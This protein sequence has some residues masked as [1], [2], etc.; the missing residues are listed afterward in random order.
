M[1]RLLKRTTLAKGPLVCC[2]GSFLFVIASISAQTTARPMNITPAEVAR[3]TARMMSHYAP[4]NMLRFTISLKSPRENELRQFNEELYDKNSPNFHK[5]LTPEQWIAR[6]APPA[7]DE[8]VVLDW[9]RSNGLTVTAQHPHRLTVSLEGTSERIES[10]FAVRMNNYQIGALSFYSND[11]DPVLPAQLAAVVES[12]DGL[13]SKAELSPASTGKRILHE[14]PAYVAGPVIAL[15][16]NGSHDADRSK[17]PAALA[18]SLAS[19]LAA[20][21]AADSADPSFTGS[22]LDPTDLYSPGAYNWQALNNLKHCCNPAHGA[23]SPREA[24]VAIVTAYA[25]DPADITGFHNAYSYLADHWTSFNIDGTPKC[26]TTDTSCNFET[27]LDFDSVT[28]MANSF[29]SAA[30]TAHVYIYQ[31]VSAQVSVVIDT[32]SQ[33]LTDNKV[34]VVTHSFGCAEGDCWNSSNMKS[35]HNVFE[36]MIAQGYTIMVDAGDQGATSIIAGGQDCESKLAVNYPASDPDVVAV[37]GTRLS[38]STTDDSFVSE[39]AWQGDTSAGSCKS[40]RGGTGGGVSTVWDRPTY[41]ADLTSSKRSMPDIALN[42]SYLQNIYYQGKLTGAFGTSIATP[43]MAGFFAQENAYLLAI[44]VGCGAGHTQTCAPLGLANTALY[45]LGK[46]PRFIGDY[47][48]FYDITSGCNSNDNTVAHKLTAYCAAPGYDNVTGWGT[49]NAL[50]LAWGINAYLAGDFI[51]PDVTFGGAVADNWY[52]LDR[53]ITWTVQDV[54]HDIFLANGVAGFSQAWDNFPD[55]LGNRTNNASSNQ[56]QFPNATTG[57]LSLAQAG[58]GCHHAILRVWDNGGTTALRSSPAYC[59]D[60]VPPT[61]KAVVTGTQSGGVFVSSATIT[62]TATDSTSGIGAISYS[63]GRFYQAYTGPIVFTQPGTYNLSYYSSDKAG[64][65]DVARGLT[66]TVKT[67]STTTN[68]SAAVN[69]SPFGAS[70]MLTAKVTPAV[71]A[72]PTGTVTFKEGTTVLGTAGLSGG[73][74]VL[75]VNGLH[76]GSHQLRAFYNGSTTAIASGS[77]TWIETISQS[78]SKTAVASTA[79]TITY[80][81]A[82]TFTASVVSS[83]GGA[84]GGSVLFK[85]GATLLGTAT[86]NATTKK[87]TLTAAA[88]AVGSHH[89]TATFS[90]NAD[91]LASTSPALIET[92]NRGVDSV[93]LSSSLNPSVFGKPITL[94]ALV[95]SQSGSPVTGTVTFKD[96]STVI[97]SAAINSSTH[98]AMIVTAALA[99]GPHALV[100]AYGGSNNYA[101][102]TSAPL[103]ESVAKAA[104]SITLAASPNPSAHGTTVKFTATVTPASGGAVSG[105]VAFEAA[106]IKFGTGV[107]NPTTHQAS[108]TTAGLSVGSHPITAKFLGS[109]NLNQSASPTV[110]QTVR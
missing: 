36:A 32:F 41:Q 5:F 6:F 18:S 87:A 74:A 67:P 4:T 56:P 85:D 97:G 38:L 110:T 71:G 7:A 44:G 88:L 62:I 73:R 30:D 10:A 39:E 49:I 17:M 75:A 90:G 95:S 37:G 24:S 25:I 21:A 59:Y 2:A 46:F 78:T 94:T 103:T 98:R 65:S 35:M 84:V 3:G 22:N 99:A 11:R 91:N 104:S 47:A 79:S 106:G 109:A 55:D 50:Y 89:I 108:Y 14:P 64:N 100:A 16:N 101:P 52:N 13:N 92:V 76:A 19:S 86:L 70:L 42:A 31:G 93:V 51:A 34:R 58:Q 9:A 96:G 29:G 102:G 26:P 23:D 27:T 20:H 15:A 83:H 43:E 8:Q 40:N 63:L 68:L 54:G 60:T 61:T 69:P 28:Q 1:L 53:P 107:V 72:A 77:N 57:S 105:T 82:A 81:Q 48:P 45:T 66:V 33:I 12:V 80:G